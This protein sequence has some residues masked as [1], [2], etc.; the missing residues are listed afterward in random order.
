[1]QFSEADTKAK[2]IDPKL[3]ES[4]RDEANIIREEYFT[5]WRKFGANTRWTPGYVDYLLKYK[6]KNLAIIEAKKSEESPTKWLEQAKTYWQKLQV[7]FVYSTNWYEIY[8]FDLKLWKWDFVDSFPSP[9]E[10]FQKIIW[11]TNH[12]K[13]KLLS[14]AYSIEWNVKPRYYQENAINKVL[15]SIADGNQRILLTLATGTWKTFI[16]F[17]IVW[18]LFQA[19]WN[20]KSNSQRPKILFLADRNI[21][22]DQAMNTFNPLEKD[23]IKIDWSEIKRRW[24][25]VPTNANIFFAIYQAISDKEN[26]W[27]YYKEY[28]SDFFD[29]VII[30]ECHRWWANE[31]WTWHEI[32][33]HFSPA[34]HLG[35]TAT[36]KRQD[37]IDTY[38]YFGEPVYEYSLKEGIND[39]FLTPYKV[40]RIQTNLD[41]FV[42]NSGDKILKWESTKSVYDIQDHERN[43]IIHERTD[44]IAQ[45]ILQN[46]NPY[47]K[48]IVFCVDQDHALRLRDAINKYKSNNEKDYCVRVTSDEWVEWKQYLERFQD[49]DKTLPVILTT[50]QMLTTG[51]DAKNVRNIV[52]LKQIGSMV[53]FKQII[54]RWTRLFEWKDYFNI[55]DFV[56]ATNNFYDEAWDGEPA[57]PVKKSKLQL[58]EDEE[59]LEEVLEDYQESAENQNESNDY[60]FSSQDQDLPKEKLEVELGDDR[61][62]KII[63]IEERFIDENWKP[64]SAEDFLQKIVGNIP[65]LYQDIDQLRQA[66]AD[67]ESREA[68]LQKLYDMWID[69][70]QLQ[71]L[72]KMF[73]ADGVDVFDILAYI[74][75]NVDMKKRK[76]RADYVRENTGILEKYESSKAKEFLEFLL[77]QYE[78]NGIFEFKSHN[79][80]A[81]IDLYHST[82]TELSKAF[83][84][85]DRLREAYF[86]LQKDIYEL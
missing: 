64:L 37:N 63:N 48:T 62:V 68:L 29:L 2:F 40:K 15:E 74:S 7:R 43:I 59:Q 85:A 28:P 73:E 26:I 31:E 5:T 42:L 12:L 75:F 6:N 39:G 49:N 50:S 66:W 21:L 67:P 57:A 16:A 46:I 11:K 33:Q 45:A 23:M 24:W 82:P 10:L 47:E 35:L 20:N 83:G 1:M 76:E 4:A 84:G 36:P 27:W 25:K 77:E 51:V 38:N 3:K 58:G 53:E 61:T 56:G 69:R 44:L 22:V 32:L 86:E 70:E 60:E 8:E 14:T 54:W 41:E 72:R 52:L 18:K 9:E 13:E 71:N 30:D 80:K 55:I 78:A 19:R 81:M 34:V 65:H 17:Q 79:L